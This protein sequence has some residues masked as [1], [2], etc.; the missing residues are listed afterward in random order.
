MG[1]SLSAPRHTCTHSSINLTLNVKS[2]GLHVKCDCHKTTSSTSAL[3]PDLQ[4]T[5]RLSSVDQRK[6]QF[7][8]CSIFFVRSSWRWLYYTREFHNHFRLGLRNQTRT[9]GGTQRRLSCPWK[10][11]F[12]FGGQFDILSRVKYIFEILLRY[13]QSTIIPLERRAMEQGEAC[14]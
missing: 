11:N 13:Y 8:N 1:S 10:E 7:M 9:C 6:A 5:R 2:L 14:D 4:R 12:L 3:T